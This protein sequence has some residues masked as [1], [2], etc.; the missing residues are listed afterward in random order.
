MRFVSLH[1][2]VPSR[3]TLLNSECAFCVGV[4]AV[5]HEAVDPA[6]ALIGEHRHLHLHDTLVVTHHRTRLSVFW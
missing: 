5:G 4:D 3:A 6:G 1:I 2:H